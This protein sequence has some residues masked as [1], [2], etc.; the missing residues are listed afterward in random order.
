MSD[1]KLSYQE[2]ADFLGL[3]VGTLYAMVSTKKIPHYRI[4][5]RLIRFSEAE[6]Q[7]WTEKHKVNASDLRGVK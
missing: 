6:L 1:R 3:P 7:R 4:S 5:K 2:A